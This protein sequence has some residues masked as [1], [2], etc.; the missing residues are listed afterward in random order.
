MA[1]TYQVCSRCILPSSF[2]GISFDDEGVCSECHR[3]DE[4]WRT[5]DAGQAERSALLERL[6]DDAR[7]RGKEFDALVPLSGGKDSLYVLY[8]ATR[9][10]GLRCLAFTLDNGFLSDAAKANIRSAC[11][12]LGVEH[13]YYNMDPQLMS[14]LFALFMRKTGD[15]CGV[16]MRAIGMATERVADMYDV[17]LILQGSSSRTELVLSREMFEP[18]PIPYIRNVLAGEEI[19]PE[20]RRL[21]HNVSMRRRLGYRVFRAERGT[22]LRFYGG[23][24][25][26]DYMDWDYD[27]IYRVLREELGWQ[28]P[29]GKAEHY[30]CQIHAVTNYMHNRRFPGL[31]IRRLTLARLAMV[32]QISREEALAQLQE[33][34]ETCPEEEMALLLDRLN[35]PREEFDRCV[36]LGPRHL[37]YQPKPASRLQRVVKRVLG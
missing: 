3:H 23:L 34:E 35:M 28:A 20:A 24:K 26:P 1:D 25:L 32:G 5:F 21:L 18:G 4:R 17:P 16:C 36:D 30:D 10:L 13:V 33:P 15:F 29:Q 9:H 19:G 12:R 11:S 2:P 14:Q 8:Q 31:E 27:T 7:A 22:R 37:L 6:C